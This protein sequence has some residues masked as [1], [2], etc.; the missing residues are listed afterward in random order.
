MGR[1]PAD[2][3]AASQAE[4]SQLR[5]RRLATQERARAA[6][7]HHLASIE[8]A[9]ARSDMSDRGRNAHERAAT[10]HERAALLHT[11]VAEL[12]ELHADNEMARANGGPPHCPS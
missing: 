1:A 9:R 7:E 8:R 2:S 4:L 3:T 12:H 10:T 6:S 11:E 5:S